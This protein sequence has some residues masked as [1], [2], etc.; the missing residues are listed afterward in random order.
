[1]IRLRRSHRALSLSWTLL[2]RVSRAG[3]GSAGASGTTRTT[4]RLRRTG[5][6]ERASLCLRRPVKVYGTVTLSPFSP[7]PHIAQGSRP[8]AGAPDLLSKTAILVG[9][10]GC[11]PQ[12]KPMLCASCTQFEA[13]AWAASSTV[14]PASLAAPLLWKNLRTRS[15]AFPPHG[16]SMARSSDSRDNFAAAAAAAAAS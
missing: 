7:P 1:M 10:A 11:G 3:G 16:P 9:L 15:F 2:R 14:H 6:A 13:S 8:D 5:A 4:P 12:S